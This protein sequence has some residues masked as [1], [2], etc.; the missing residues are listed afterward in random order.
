MTNR[1]HRV[2]CTQYMRAPAVG[3]NAVWS[4]VH[5]AQPHDIVND[6][7]ILSWKGPKRSL[8]RAYTLHSVYALLAMSGHRERQ[9]DCPVRTRLQSLKAKAQKSG[10]VCSFISMTQPVC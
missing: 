7:M 9:W 8:G 3:N 4:A 10:G 1:P 5:A 2:V 6:T